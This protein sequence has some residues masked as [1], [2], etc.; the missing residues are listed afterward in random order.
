[1]RPFDR[2]RAT[3]CQGRHAAGVIDMAVRHQNLGQ[4]QVFIAQHLHDAVDV[5]AGVNHGR[6][7]SLFAPENSAV[8][9][10]WRDGNNG[11]AHDKNRNDWGS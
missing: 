1:M 7:T 4:R 3:F 9:I 5:A 6:L 10:E 11:V 8:L 2:H